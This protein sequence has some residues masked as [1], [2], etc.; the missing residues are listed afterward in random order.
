MNVQMAII[1]TTLPI[2]VLRVIQLAAHVMMAPKI[3][4]SAAPMSPMEALL[5]NT[6]L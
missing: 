3:I 2:Y 1:E 4:V 6:I 5:L